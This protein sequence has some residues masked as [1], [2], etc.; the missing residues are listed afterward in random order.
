MKVS[1]KVDYALQAVIEI[2]HSSNRD[3]LISAEDIA[4]KHQIPEKFLE[5]ILT[6]LRKAGLINSFRGP[7]G[8]YQLAKPAE[9]IT[10]ADVIRTIDG[11]LAA[12]RGYAPEEIE[13]RGSVKHLDQIWIATR[14]ALREVLEHITISDALSGE[15]DKEIGLML[16]KKDA[17]KRRKI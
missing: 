8:G 11:P 2:A 15:F 5:G 12:V 1:A 9:Q 14:S 4:G 10:I 7:S 17:R 3:Q 13:Y 16:V 6:T